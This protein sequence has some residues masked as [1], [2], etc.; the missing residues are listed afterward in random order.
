V[1]HNTYR[2][3]KDEKERPKVKS[4][5]KY[6][7]LPLPIYLIFLLVVHSISIMRLYKTFTFFFFAQSF[8]LIPSHWGLTVIKWWP[9]TMLRSY[10]LIIICCKLGR[11][12]LTI[13]LVYEVKTHACL[14]RQ[15]SANIIPTH[16]SCIKDCWSC[17]LVY[18]SLGSES[19]FIQGL[20]LWIPEFSDTSR[21][22]QDR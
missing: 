17:T 8:A 10:L 19:D 4:R 1:I 11:R 13:L 16:L 2:R 3:A 15:I 21:S 12:S 20:I 7:L 22:K 5:K 6:S 18:T 14:T 9:A